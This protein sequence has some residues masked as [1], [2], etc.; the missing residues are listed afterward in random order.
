[1]KKLKCKF[2][3]QQDIY[4]V[5]ILSGSIA[6]ESL[7]SEMVSGCPTSCNVHKPGNCFKQVVRHSKM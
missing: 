3:G 5:I 2:L 4:A 1:M 7:Y 6:E